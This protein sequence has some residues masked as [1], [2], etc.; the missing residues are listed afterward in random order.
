MDGG[1]SGK[2]K[3]ETENGWWNGA[4]GCPIILVFNA[5]TD[6]TRNMFLTFLIYFWLLITSPK[7]FPSSRLKYNRLLE[8]ENINA[9]NWLV[10]T[11]LIFYCNIIKNLIFQPNARKKYPPFWKWKKITILQVWQEGQT[12][13][14]CDGSEGRELGYRDPSR[15]IWRIENIAL[16]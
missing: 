15:S 6:K 7:P 11:L 13:L 4:T 3:Q 2:G 10:H 5:R 8:I 9:I 12:D 1:G 16:L 14:G